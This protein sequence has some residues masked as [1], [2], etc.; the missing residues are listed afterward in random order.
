M[1]KAEFDD[2]KQQAFKEA[3]AKT[4]G[5]GVRADHVLIGTIEEMSTA[6]RR[7]LAQGIRVAV[8]VNAPDK[9]AAAAIVASL[10]EAGINTE[11]KNVGLPPATVLEAAAV[12]EATQF[13]VNQTATVEVEAS[14][15]MGPVA[16]VGVSFAA[17]IVFTGVAAWIVK[18]L[19]QIKDKDRIL[20]LLDMLDTAFDWGS[21]VG[22][23]LEG[24]F[25]F[26]NDKDK[27][28]YWTLC[29]ISIFGTVLFLISTISMWRFNRRFK[30]IIV[31]QLG[32]ENFAQGI[33][34]IIVASS[35]ASSAN[36]RVSVIVGITQALCFCGFQIFE[37][38]GLQPTD[39]VA[40]GGGAGGNG[41]TMA[42]PPS[43]SP[44]PSPS[45]SLPP[46]SGGG[47]PVVVSMSPAAPIA[48]PPSP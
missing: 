3:I 4:A 23:N 22:T 12:L 9:D 45:P 41:I 25:T 30:W 16:T 5:Q 37:L 19:P 15:L 28:V 34:Y 43:Q 36:V 47:Q 17:S 48:T 33:L 39:E 7:L 38:K 1:T 13:N 11:L 2:E 35:Q 31:L 32:F 20:Y 42:R 10:T 29:A 26:S 27:V 14:L 24:D 44:P 21:W 40:D 18:D 46:T 8:S 6:A